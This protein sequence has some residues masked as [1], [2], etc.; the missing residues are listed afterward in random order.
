ML[1][2]MKMWNE[3]NILRLL[4]GESICTAIME[5]TVAVL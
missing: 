2:L 5:I 1:M 4:V 3:E